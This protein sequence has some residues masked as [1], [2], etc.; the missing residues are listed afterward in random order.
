MD[1]PIKL[2]LRK[3]VA[4]NAQSLYAGA[5]KAR[6]KLAGARKAVADTERKIS[7]LAAKHQEESLKAEGPQK[8]KKTEKKWFEK[9][10][11]FH[12]TDGFLVVCGKDATSNEVLIKK[13]LNNEDLVFHADIH[14]APFCVIKNPEKK[15]IP[16]NTKKETAEAAASYSKAWK[17]GMGSCDIYYVLPDQVSKSAPSGEYVG[18]G[19]FMIYGKKE[20]LRGTA[21]E[22]AV[23]LVLGEET[24]AISGPVAAVAAR[25]RHYVK[26][27]P[28]DRKS[29]EL[30]RDIKTGLLKKAG[31]EDAEKM[32]RAS[33]EDIQ[34]LIPGG[35]GRIAS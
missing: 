27:A 26:I 7:E 8:K 10:H 35:K 15:E 13:H 9:F 22:I 30:A 33:L 20:W 19:G 1:Q 32:K 34:R 4:E 23:G 2:D 5:K 31:K 12:S 14:G 29:G 6:E 11:Y 3:S 16:E 21:T 28:G 18:K 24:E 17:L 25:T